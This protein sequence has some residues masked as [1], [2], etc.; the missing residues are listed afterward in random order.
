MYTSGQSNVVMILQK[1]PRQTAK[2]LC[3]VHK[4]D[5]VIYMLICSWHFSWSCLAAKIISTAFLKPHW[6][7]GK[8]GHVGGRAGFLQGL[9]LQRTKI[10]LCDYHSTIDFPFAY[11]YRLLIH[12]WT[13]EWHV[14]EHT[15]HKEISQYINQTRTP[16][17]VDIR[18]NGD[19]SWKLAVGEAVCGF[20]CFLLGAAR[21]SLTWARGRRLMDIEEV[22][23]TM[24]V[25]MRLNLICLILLRSFWAVDIGSVL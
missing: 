10:S 15:F 22:L 24:P 1:S 13:L 14:S 20:Y 6:L 25:N 9:C 4:S 12:L 23:K 16:G 21:A 17:F 2:S 19:S 11:A 7:S 5:V 18:W 3:K 8:D